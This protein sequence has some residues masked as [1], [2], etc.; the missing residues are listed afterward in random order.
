MHAL[1]A[2]AVLVSGL[3]TAD[4]TPL[5][6]CTVS[7]ESRSYSA[8]KTSGADGKYAFA[9]VP[10]GT[11]D[12]KFH[13]D[14]LQ[15]VTRL[16]TIGETDRV[17]AAEDL[18]L[19]VTESITLACG[20]PCN[21]SA[22]ATRWDLPTC[23]D[24]ELDTAL[25]ESLRNGDRSARDLLLQRYERA[26]TWTEQHRVGGALLGRIP[27][28]AAIWNELFEHATNAVRLSH[29]ETTDPSPELVR[30]CEERQFDVDNYMSMAID[31][32]EV[33][34]HDERARPL[35]R[36]ALQA[37]EQYLLFLAIT[38]LGEQHDEN[39]LPAIE[40]T[41]ERLPDEAPML[42][43]ALAA[44]KSER[45]DAI[46]KKYVGEDDQEYQQWRNA[47]R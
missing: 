29:D 9:G 13:L 34:S 24:Y 43:L 10:A 4:Y 32:F 38:G 25:I 21:D 16:V 44:F 20:G 37:N 17:I 7:L 22:P 42:T 3:V 18:Q 40:K 15:D 31:A 36:Q 35:L 2:A 11:Y 26:D 46:A 1:F 47:D 28:D 41:L 30:W 39:A 14:G 23:T 6:G 8:V 45:A 5:P 27:N 12:L 19:D 33:A